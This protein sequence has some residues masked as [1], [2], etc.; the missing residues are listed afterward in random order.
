MVKIETKDDIT[1]IQGTLTAQSTED[2]PLKLEL[3][4][5][6]DWLYALEEEVS[7]CAAKD[8]NLTQKTDFYIQL[9]RQNGG[10]HELSENYNNRHKNIVIHG[11]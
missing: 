10:A 1:L 4:K 9:A 3:T 2:Q 6:F 8:I 5:Q 7:T 11:L